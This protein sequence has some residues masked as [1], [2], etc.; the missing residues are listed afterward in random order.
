MTI[1]VAPLTYVAVIVKAAVLAFVVF[2][3]FL[4]AS[5]LQVSVYF[6]TF[7][8]AVVKLAA[9]VGGIA[10]PVNRP[11]QVM[12]VMAALGIGGHWDILKLPRLRHYR[13]FTQCGMLRIS[14]CL[15]RNR[16]AACSQ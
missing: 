4:V 15:G 6:H 3:L 14:G 7:E 12:V 2:A 5:V 1:G 9:A 10:I 11:E 8:M 13:I 16:N